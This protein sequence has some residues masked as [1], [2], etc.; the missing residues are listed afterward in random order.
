MAL[1]SFTLKQCTGTDAVTET[2]LSDFKAY[3]RSA[4]QATGD[5]ADDPVPAPVGAATEAWSFELWL[6][7]IC[8][9]P[10]D[11]YCQNFKVWGPSTQPDDPANK[12]TIYMG[13]TDTGTTPTNDHDST[14]VADTTQHDNYYNSAT[15]LSIG[16]EPSD[17]KIEAVSEK[18]DYVVHQLEV[19][20]GASQG[21][22]AL[23]P[24]K[25][26]FEEV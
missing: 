24:M 16:V 14:S 5:P 25:W 8:A 17:A 4:D 10:P 1:A 2:T 22:L 7:L 26:G 13:T 3:F 6:R 15:G 18:T 9:T 12:I 21:D 23:V 11:N 20:P 19:T